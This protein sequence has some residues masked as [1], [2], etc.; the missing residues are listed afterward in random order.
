MTLKPSL[1]ML[2]QYTEL[3]IGLAA[4]NDFGAYAEKDFNK[5]FVTNTNDIQAMI[6]GKYKFYDTTLPKGVPVKLFRF[7]PKEAGF[8]CLDF[9]IKNGVNGIAIFKRMT[10][11]KNI[12]FS[13][14]FNKTTHVKTPNS[15]YHFYF[16]GKWDAR[17]GGLKKNIYPGVETKYKEALTAAG[18]IK[19]G[20]LY[21]LK[22]ELKSALELPKEIELLAKAKWSAPQIQKEAKTEKIVTMEILLDE[23]VKNP[24]VTGHNYR[25]F[26]FSLKCNR[27][28][29]PQEQTLDYVYSNPSVFGTD[30]DL[31]KTVASGYSY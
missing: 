19:G 11:N 18:S 8:F 22:G 17:K 7:I 2:S 13:N 10:K 5:R 3:G 9:D 31:K 14:I 27:C 20:K 30:F 24:K 1:E 21:E 4:V 26:I 12:D 29:I 28:N 6:E 25:A 23:V 16:R 15:G